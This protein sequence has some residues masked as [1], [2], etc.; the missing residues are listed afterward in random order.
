MEEWKSVGDKKWMSEKWMNGG[1][2]ESLQDLHFPD[3]GRV[4]IGG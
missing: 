1:G 2:S 3:G 4:E